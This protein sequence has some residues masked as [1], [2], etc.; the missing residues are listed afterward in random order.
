MKRSTRSCGHCCPTG[1]TRV[2][3]CKPIAPARSKDRLTTMN[4]DPREQLSALMDG[5]LAKDE[6]RFLLRRFDADADLAPNWSRYH[7]AR[8]SLRRQEVLPLRGD[9]AEVILQRIG[10]E[11]VHSPRHRTAWLRWASGGAIAASVGM[12]RWRQ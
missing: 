3:S 9:F 7:V 6:L 5:E 4:H 2:D 11:T 8:Y 12:P 1:T 10:A